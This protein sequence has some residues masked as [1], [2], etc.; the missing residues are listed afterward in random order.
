LILDLQERYKFLKENYEKKQN[1]NL[2]NS[3]DVGTDKG[4]YLDKTLSAALDSFDNLFC[5][6]CLVCIQRPFPFLLSVLAKEEGIKTMLIF[7]GISTA[8]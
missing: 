2:K 4:I 5:R 1:K 7:L 8:I 3:G 6:R